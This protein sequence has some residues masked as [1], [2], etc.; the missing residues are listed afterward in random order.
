MLIMSG[1]KFACSLHHSPKT[2]LQQQPGGQV[3]VYKPSAVALVLWK[4][5]GV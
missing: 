2:A 1:I 5:P 3:N 4:N